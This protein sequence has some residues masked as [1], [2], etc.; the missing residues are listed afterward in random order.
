MIRYDDHKNDDDDNNYDDHMVTWA[1]L[2]DDDA[3]FNNYNCDIDDNDGNDS[4]DILNLG[5]CVR[6]V[7]L[8]KVILNWL[9]TAEG[10]VP[11][12]GF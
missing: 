10:C 8:T 6:G 1:E 5:V 9:N 4:D 3:D 12:G 11:L 2:S 7:K